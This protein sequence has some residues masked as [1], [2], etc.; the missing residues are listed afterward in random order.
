MNKKVTTVIGW[1]ITLV[2]AIIG[3]FEATKNIYSIEMNPSQNITVNI[4]G[5]EVD[6]NKDNAQDVYDEIENDKNSLS[7]QVETLEEKNQDLNSELARYKEYGTSALVSKN[8]SFDSNRISLLAFEPVNQHNWNP[9]EG[10]LK[11]SLGNIYTVSLDYLVL[12]NGNYG[13][14]YTNGQFSKLQF[15]LAPH[16]TM[17]QDSSA[18]IKVFANDLLVFTSDEITRKSEAETYTVDINNAKFIKIVCEGINGWDNNV[19]LLDST[20]IK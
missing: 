12:D 2:A 13:E 5:K 7:S 16:E 1:V 9:N 3:T 19:M 17:G 10:T 15:R 4:D 20:L 6:I 11:D 18:V 8:K 14:Y